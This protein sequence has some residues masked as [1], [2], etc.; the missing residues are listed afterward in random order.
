MQ[1]LPV[2]RQLL[3]KRGDCMYRAVVTDLDGTLLRSDSSISPRTA[4]AL[5][6]LQDRG[7]PVIACTGRSIS[8]AMDVL[9]GY[10]L[11]P[12]MVLLTGALVMNV[13]SGEILHRSCIAPETAAR[14]AQLLRREETCFFYVYSGKT[15][16]AFPEMRQ[17]VYRSDMNPKDINC[18]LRWMQCQEALAE[19]LQTGS[20]ACEKIFA[21]LGDP[22]RQEALE[23]EICKLAACNRAGAGHLEILAPGNSKRTGLLAACM[24]LGL[25][26]EH[27]IAFGDSENDIPLAQT[28]AAF[29]A[30]EN[31]DSDLMKLSTL[32]TASN[33]ADGVAIMIEDLLK[34]Q[35]FEEGKTPWI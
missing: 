22:E 26:P 16:Y 11:H 34:N 24:Q 21:I 5:Q 32:Q 28:C 18:T 29:V 10:P 3:F 15:L 31:A 20:I 35:Q 17:R 8:E 7:I 4:S 12:V 9:S 1:K 19:Q 30:M 6:A 2:K 13:R 25:N 33:N 23:H 14:I 27:I